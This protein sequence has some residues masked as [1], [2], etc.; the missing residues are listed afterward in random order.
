MKN[1]KA[2]ALGG[3]LGALA[4]TVMLLG[5]LVPLSTY[6]CPILCALIT[7]TVLIFCGGRIAAA[8]YFMVAFLCLLLGPD[9]EASSLFALIGYYPIIKP[10][11]EKLPLPVLWKLLLFNGVIVVMYTAMV[12][13]FGF[14]PLLYEKNLIGYITLGVTVLL[15]NATFFLLDKLLNKYSHK[16]TRK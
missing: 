4:V 2:I 10:K 9:K 13:V 5:G 8:W 15:G 6:I 12:A 1:A 16:K 11:I 3:V 7:Q 14:E